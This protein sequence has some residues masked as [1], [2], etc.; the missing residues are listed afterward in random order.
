MKPLF[1]KGK[2][3]GVY[4]R[5]FALFL[6]LVMLVAQFAVVAKFFAVL[7]AALVSSRGGPNP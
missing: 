6:R 7:L 5:R 2:R 3:L 1:A 4:V